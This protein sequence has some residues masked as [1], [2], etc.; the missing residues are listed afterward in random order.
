M[1]QAQVLQSRRNNKAGTLYCDKA[2]KSSC[3][4]AVKP[5]C[6]KAVKPSC[7]KA[8]TPSCDNE[9]IAKFC[10]GA[11]CK[12]NQYSNNTGILCNTAETLCFNNVVKLSKAVKCCSLLSSKSLRQKVC[13]RTCS[14]NNRTIPFNRTTIISERI[15]EFRGLDRN[16][17]VKFS[18]NWN[19]RS[20]YRCLFLN[21]CN[22]MKFSETLFLENNLIV[23]KTHP[24]PRVT[25][26]VPWL[27]DEFMMNRFCVSISRCYAFV[28]RCYGIL[29]NCNKGFISPT[30]ASP[31]WC[32]EIINH[33]LT[34]HTKRSR[35]T[36]LL[37]GGLG[38]QLFLLLHII[39]IIIWGHIQNSDHCVG[40]NAL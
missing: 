28:A 35:N 40:F 36:M 10:R 2:V 9:Y 4:K 38:V 34:I 8:V 16:L 33:S 7:D 17:I 32:S 31:I 15:V 22:T 24:Q 14:F 26:I 3:D 1:H 20:N 23:L 39:F 37:F 27:C 12:T 25:Y 13:A 6:D 30:V 19:G 11:V 29:L 21:F 18:D 5:S